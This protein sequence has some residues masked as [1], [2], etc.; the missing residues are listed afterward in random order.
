MTSEEAARIIL[1]DLEEPLEDVGL[2]I[3]KIL[4]NDPYHFSSGEEALAKIALAVY[5]GDSEARLIDIAALD[6]TNRKR[7][8]TTLMEYWA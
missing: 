7:V 8:L 1:G 5:N 6:S 3:S 4:N 2:Q